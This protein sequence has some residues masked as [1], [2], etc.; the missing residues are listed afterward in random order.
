M[1]IW[2]SMAHDKI[3]GT[4]VTFNTL[5][6]GFAK[7][8]QYTD[9]RDVVSEFERIRL[10]PTVLTYNMLMNAYVRGGQHL[11]LPQLYKEMATHNL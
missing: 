6:D 8:G 11:K 7:Q 9:V 3:E 2:K 10:P 1:E 5:L 4:R